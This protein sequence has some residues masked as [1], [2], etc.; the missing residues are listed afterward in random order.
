VA[1]VTTVVGSTMTWAT[2]RAFGFVEFSVA[3]LDADQHGR[4][5]VALGLLLGLAALGLVVRR[6][7]AGARLLAGLAGL[8]ISL[9]ALIDIGYLR[10]GGLLSGTGVQATTVIG[11]GLWLILGSG[12]LALVAAALARPRRGQPG[13]ERSMTPGQ[14]SAAEK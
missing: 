7:G 8:T 9:T 5:T 10:G 14:G 6:G 12:L 1:A 11:P 3:G 4:L 13:S 2:V